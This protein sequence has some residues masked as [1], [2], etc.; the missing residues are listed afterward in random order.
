VAAAGNSGPYCGSVEDPPATYPETLTVG[1]VDQE[2]VLTD[3]S[4]RGPAPD[5]TVKPDVVAPG[6]HIL[7]AL[8]GGGYGYLDGT[9]MAAPHVAGV[10]ALMWSANPRLVGDIAGTTEMLRRL[11]T[12]VRVS[13]ATPDCGGSDTGAG[14]IDAF[15]A[16]K[17]A[18]SL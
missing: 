7:S 16:V 10:V 5:G 17:E 12:P 9:S 2:D 13:S 14:E 8:P 4:S 18:Q 1:A 15:A 3:F 6:A 11:A